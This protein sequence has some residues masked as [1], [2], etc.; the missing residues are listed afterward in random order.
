MVGSNIFNI[1]GILGLTAIVTPVP[2]DASMASFDIP[3][4]LAVSL[5]LAL[6][7]TWAG[8]IGR[9]P[10][11]AMVGVYSGYVWWLL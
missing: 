1:L 6:L 7:V 2:I 11:V 4:M 5:A 8:R 3:V 10:G 9:L